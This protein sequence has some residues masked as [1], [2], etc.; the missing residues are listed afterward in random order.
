MENQQG[1]PA[2]VEF[3]GKE[4]SNDYGPYKSVLFLRS[5]M[6]GDRAKVWR[7]FPPEQ[8]DSFQ[9]NEAVLLIPTEKN[10]K[11][12]WEIQRQQGPQPAPSQPAAG[13]LAAPAPRTQAPRELDAAQKRAIASYI[14]QQAAIFGYCLSEARETLPDLSEESYRAI[15]A[16]LYIAAQRRFGL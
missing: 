6:E 1:I 3:I 2:I 14:S 16:T 7:S 10:G 11:P 12:S 13:G 4:K 8:A 15:A 5:D 9:V